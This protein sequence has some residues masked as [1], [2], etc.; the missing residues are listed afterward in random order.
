MSSDLLTG[1]A[2]VLEYP[3]GDFRVR[4]TALMARLEVERPEAA[5]AMGEFLGATGPV[6]AT[7]LEETYAATFD[8]NPVCCLN[9][10]YQLFGESY[11]RGA[12]MAQLNADYRE[13][14]FEAGNELP[15]HLPVILRFLAVLD[16]AEHRSWLLEE[17]VLPALAKMAGG[18]E[19]TDS[20][21]GA[22]VRSALLTLQPPGFVL[23]K[24]DSRT[25][26]VLGADDHTSWEWNDGKH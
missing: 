18:F 4:C 21:Y 25:L 14:D 13:R 10:G 7:A 8:L 20:V 11:K 17:A 5:E 19:G 26:P 3:G 23:R 2:D 1:L 24:D 16:D 15:D 6:S 9:V 22:L 12:F